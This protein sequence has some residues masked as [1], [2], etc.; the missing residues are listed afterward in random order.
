MLHLYLY[1]LW[2]VFTL[3][4]FLDKIILICSVLVHHG[5]LMLVINW[6]LLRPC[7]K[8]WP[9][10]LIYFLFSSFLSLPLITC[11]SLLLP[12]H[13]VSFLLHCSSLFFSKGERRYP[14][15]GS[16]IDDDLWLLKLLAPDL[17][18][19]KVWQSGTPCV[20][21]NGAVPV[22]QHQPMWNPV[23]SSQTTLLED[24]LGLCINTCD[25]VERLHLNKRLFSLSV[26]VPQWGE[27]FWFDSGRNC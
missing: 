12:F 18:L 11:F 10:I 16:I 25:W 6:I 14:D 1:S 3:K 4:T 21:I 27:R 20:L 8:H 19:F 24:N 23:S 17:E 22:T 15:S 13:L 2:C 7:W 26:K 5:L 9:L